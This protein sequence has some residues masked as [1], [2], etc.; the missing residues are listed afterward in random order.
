[1]Q[2]WDL[3]QRMFGQL[4][5]VGGVN[6]NQVIGFDMNVAFSLGTA[7]SVPA[8]LIAEW[9]PAIEGVIVTKLNERAAEDE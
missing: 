5:V 3:T 2:I 7:L 8:E 4:R 6:G 9:M 1:M